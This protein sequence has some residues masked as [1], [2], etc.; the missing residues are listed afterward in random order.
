MP[1]PPAKK[2]SP[3]GPSERS[4]MCP[5]RARTDQVCRQRSQT[6]CFPSPSPSES[7][8]PRPHQKTARSAL[9]AHLRFRFSPSP[10]LQKAEFSR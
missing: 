4:P 1:A 2:P 5:V 8:L 3:K 7:N 10:A 6:P 9:P